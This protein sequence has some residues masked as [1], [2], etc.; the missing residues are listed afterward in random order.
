[1]ARRTRRA[2]K[3]QLAERTQD[4]SG[5]KFTIQLHDQTYR[6]RAKAGEAIAHWVRDTHFR[7]EH[8]N[9]RDLGQ[10]GTLA[11]HPIHATV[12]GTVNSGQPPH[13]PRIHLHVPGTLEDHAVK[14]TAADLATTDHRVITSLESRITAIGRDAAGFERQLPQRETELAE[15]EKNLGQP[16]KHAHLL[17]LTREQLA[18][19]DQKM[20]AR[21]D[22]HAPEEPTEPTFPAAPS[23]STPPRQHD[24]MPARQHWRQPTPA[25]DQGYGR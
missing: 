17:T 24:S 5:D 3:D 15:A 16:F 10:I 9:D 22:D 4:V 13:N 18:T 21:D 25:N 11:G 2:S 8:M 1:M 6:E 23:A 19:V 7:A 12:I 14:M 20:A